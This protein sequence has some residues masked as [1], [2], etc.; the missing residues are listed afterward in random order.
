LSLIYA[1]RFGDGRAFAQLV[2]RY[3]NLLFRFALRFVSSAQAAEE[4]AHDTLVDF[5]RNLDRYEPRTALGTYLC[6]ILSKKALYRRRTEAHAPAALDG[7]YAAAAPSGVLE[8]LLREEELLSVKKRVDGLDPPLRL[9]VE[10]HYMEGMKLREIARAMSIPVGTVKSRLN[11]ALTILRKGF[12]T[13][14][15]R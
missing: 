5:Y 11:A 2:D 3:A 8:K 12:R 1:A 14:E 6:A 13:E 15:K 4:L 10:M 9:A 7:E